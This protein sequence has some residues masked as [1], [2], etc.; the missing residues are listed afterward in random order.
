M[1]NTEQTMI[2]QTLTLEN[3]TLRAQ[4]DP[5]TGALISLVNA[6]TSWA[7]QRRPA[8]GR[9]FEMLVPLP[10]RRNNR[11]LGLAQDAPRVE[12]A[13]DGRRLTF[14]WDGVRSEFGG[15]HAITFTG[16]VTLGEDGLTFEGEIDNRSAYPIE[17]VCWP[18]IG[19][20]SPVT[21]DGTLSRHCM[22][23]GGTSSAPVYPNPPGMV[24]YWGTNHVVAHPVYSPDSPFVLVADA[25]QGLY[26]GCHAP[27]MRESV[28]YFF[29]YFPGYLESFTAQRPQGDSLDEKP[30]HIVLNCVHLPFVQPHERYT[31]SPMVLQPYVG[32]WHAGVATYK[33]WRQ[34]WFTPAPAPTWIN[35]IHAWQQFQ[36]N[37]SEDT[38]RLAYR[39]LVGLA[40][41]CAGHG[42]TAIHLTGWQDGGQDGNVPLLETDSRLG[43][44]EDLRWAIAEAKALGVRI[45]PACGFTFA[46]RAT[47]WFRDTG[48]SLAVHSPIGDTYDHLGN[49]QETYSQFLI[50]HTRVMS[51]MCV[52]SAEYRA[53]AAREFAK[54][55]A[56]QPDGIC[57]DI[58]H[59]LFFARYCFD[60]GHGH[61]VPAHTYQGDIDFFA[62]LQASA[63]DLVFG[64]LL[65]FEPLTQ[66]YAF[67]TV[68]VE[69]GSGPPLQRYLAP[70]MPLIASV[71]GSNDRNTLNKCLQYRYLISYE[72]AFTRGR[73]ADFPGTLAYGKLIDALRT[74]Y[75][76]YLWE[77]E[78]R[79]TLGAAVTTGDA[80]LAPL[81]YAVFHRADGK[82]AVVACNVA[83]TPRTVS[84][85]L[86]GGASGPLSLVTPE[87]PDAEPTAGTVTIL[88]CSVVVVLEG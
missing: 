23:G 74:R 62:Q 71:T 2:N 11:V 30:V 65:P 18:A 37:S 39:D 44:A 47:N 19:D 77:G 59:H 27:E 49:T 55:L 32:D 69:R 10:G 80:S 57:Y 25:E 46:D 50:I 52:S 20:L 43:S 83:A 68:S 45:I 14:I 48:H 73:L 16:T 67:A 61:R 60:P 70:F 34:T 51:V 54:L 24:G 36:I 8:L 13:A 64:G 58:P 5:C 79:D 9:T 15:T 17:T 81:D 40:R 1:Q 4:F 56:L 3:A 82:R 86:D 28:A 35:D 87:A 84:I 6:R 88:P 66:Q 38:P 29:E 72:P 63:P 41:E 75:R 76:A 21:P 22:Q 31:L 33:T 78:F 12:V 42:V 26:L 53:F 7:I 85:T